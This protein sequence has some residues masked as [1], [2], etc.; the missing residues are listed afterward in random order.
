[1][2]EFLWRL[3]ATIRRDKLAAEKR[4]ELEF[5]HQ[6]EVDRGL[7]EG[8]DPE[9]ARREARYRA[10]TVNEGL[11][12][13]RQEMGVGWLDGLM[14]D[15]RHA[16]RALSRNPRFAATA[17]LVLAGSVA[18]NTLIFC[19]LDGVILRPLPYT[20][21]ERLVRIY[22]VGNTEPKFPVAIGH[23]LDYRENSKAIE[24]IALYTGNDMELSGTQRASESL[25]GLH[26][27]P[28]YFRVLGKPP[29]LGRAF[30]EA[31][32]R[33]NVRHV[34]I[35]HRVWRDRFQSDRAIVGK[36]IRLNRAPWT[37]IGVA[38][39]G[40]Q[41]V[42]GEY[43]SPLQGETVD[44]FMP[45]TY[46]TRENALRAFH[47]SNAIAKVR[48]GYS[49]AQVRDELAR[50]RA[51]YTKRYPDYG[52]W[53][54]RIEPLLAEVNGRS[55]QTI[56]LLAIAA[57]LVL[58]VTCADLAG[59]SIARAVSRRPELSLRHALGATG[60][61]LARV[62][63]AENLLIGIGGGIL[64]LA[65][66]RAGLPWMQSLLPADF[67]RAHEVTLTW[68]GASFA[69]VIAMLTV[70]LAGLL[71]LIGGT[72]SATSSTSR[73]TPARDSRRLRTAL[74]IGEVA[75]AGWLCAAS[76]FLYRSYQELGARDHGFDATNTLT[77]RIAAPRQGPPQP[78]QVPQLYENIQS[79][80]RALPGVKAV[81]A[82][83][84]LPWSG[85]DENTGF[86][87]VGRPKPLAGQDPAARYQA[88]MAGYFEAAG[89]RLLKGR[90]FDQAIDTRE[91]PKVV[92]VNEALATRY[93]PAGDAVGAKVNL[94]GHE[95]EIV[96]VVASVRD[97]PADAETKPAFWFPMAQEGFTNVFFAVRTVNADPTSLTNAIAAAVHAVDPDLPLADVRT[98]ES[99]AAG[100]FA[101]RRFA[102]WLFQAFA[103]L[104]LILAAAGIYGLLAYLVHQRRRELGIRIALGAS[105][106]E[107]C[108][109]VLSDG[110]R[111]TIAGVVVCLAFIP[112]GGYLMRAFLFNVKPFDAVTLAGATV[113]LLVIALVACL[114]PA[115]TASQSDPA[116]VL[117]DN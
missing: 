40:F 44:L 67:P 75:L 30:E 24:S 86:E 105:R 61:Q 35:S 16:A 110:F 69:V 13:A 100:A 9:Q 102:L 78:G 36:S 21:P 19:L 112:I 54:A 56:W 80:I 65:L 55:S 114:G 49:Q 27:T 76:L 26:V 52:N 94:W 73:M 104:V 5:H 46:P 103:V 28:D 74:V 107:L 22:D 64:G 99:R 71:P 98:L 29:Q 88:A 59:L 31:D 38:A 111:M 63:L 15:F 113:A 82:T 96:G 48:E 68:L 58:L 93:F 37:V 89:M 14:L 108:L 11:E 43:R 101:G 18:V 95:R 1:M 83:T 85:Y 53:G 34:V 8:L 33:P 51:D 23:Y 91:K 79:Q 87:I 2:R 3:W 41:H 12:S 47:F 32:M 72:E 81:G 20:S 92:I 84:N 97:Y 10:G 25:P 115:R 4:S 66:A 117:R 109:L 60:W 70:I 50:L 90:L 116:L 62:G 77:F 39:P 45:L 42:G 17:V 6:M 7:R 57:G 106:L